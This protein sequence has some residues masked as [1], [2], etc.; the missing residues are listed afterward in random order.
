MRLLIAGLLAASLAVGAWAAEKFEDQS[1]K[2]SADAPEGFVKLGE[3]PP[4]DNFIGEAK[5]LYLSPDVANNGGAMLVHHMEIPAGA[6]Y[7]AFKG[8]IAPQLELVFGNGYK[9]VKQEDVEIG[10]L[11]GFV[12]EFACPGDGTK[13]VPGGSIPHHLRWYFFKDSPTKLIGVLYG[14]R[15]SAWK[16]LS[17]KYV[18][19]EKTLKR[20]E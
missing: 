9:L 18:A 2:V 15:D 6:D 17:D 4:K 8:A 13:P 20:V 1:I 3:L 14:A 12:L 19:S 7:A 10:K 16:E 5:G 11:S